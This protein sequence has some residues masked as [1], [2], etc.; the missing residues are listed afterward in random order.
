MTETTSIVPLTI[1]IEVSLFYESLHA[2][3]P[4]QPI[5]TFPWFATFP[6]KLRS[7]TLGWQTTSIVL[8]GKHALE[9]KNR[10]TG[11]S[12]ASPYL[13]YS[14]DRLRIPTAFAF[15]LRLTRLSDIRTSL[16]TR[17][18]MEVL[19]Y[20]ILVSGEERALGRLSLFGPGV[21]DVSVDWTGEGNR[22]GTPIAAVLGRAG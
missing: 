7:S 3:T 5:L 9:C 15:R 14:L 16:Q 4:V 18:S 13:G 22:G 20:L 2:K 11:L 17:V 6:L 19:I 10:T 1:P 12:S 21:L 8:L